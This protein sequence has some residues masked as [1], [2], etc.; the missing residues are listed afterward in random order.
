MYSNVQNLAHRTLYRISNRA[1]LP[2]V[3]QLSVRWSVRWSV[4]WSVRWSVRNAFISNELRTEE[5][6]RKWL[7]NFRKQYSTCGNDQNHLL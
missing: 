1:V 2:L 6:G 4:H 5:Y 7:G 3:R